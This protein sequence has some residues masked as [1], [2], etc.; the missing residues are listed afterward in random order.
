LICGLEPKWQ[1]NLWESK[2]Y[3]LIFSFF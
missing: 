3:F 2:N 1:R